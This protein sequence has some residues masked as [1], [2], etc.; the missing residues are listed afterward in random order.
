MFIFARQ[1]SVG[2]HVRIL[3]HLRVHTVYFTFS[4]TDDVPANKNNEVFT[5]ENELRTKPNGM[6]ES[7]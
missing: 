3:V 7:S 6:I 1:L 5:I 4:V 2:V